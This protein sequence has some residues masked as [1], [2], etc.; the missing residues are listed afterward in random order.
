M[1]TLLYIGALI[2]GVA[3]IALATPFLVCDPVPG[4]L[5]QFTKPVSYVLTGL[6]GSPIS[7][8]ATVN[9]DGTV[10]LHYDLSALTHGTFTVTA[11]AVNQFGGVSGAS[12]PFSFGVGVPAIP[13]SLRIVP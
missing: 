3:R 11:A 5:D 4:N 8:P 9:G 13:T 2:F 1:R 6:S 7:T 10:Q 12:D